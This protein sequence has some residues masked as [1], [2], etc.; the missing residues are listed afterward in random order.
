MKF[1]LLRFGAL[2]VVLLSACSP[3]QKLKKA[4]AQTLAGLRAHVQYLADDKLEGRRT[5]TKGE[6]AAADYITSQFKSIGLKPKGDILVGG[7]Q[8]YDQPFEVN[9]GKQIDSTTHLYINGTELVVGTDYFPFAFSANGAGE[10][11]PSIA[12]REQGVPWFIDLKDAL[13]ENKTNP[14][15][16]LLDFIHTYAGKLSQR[17]A[18]TALV[19][20]NSTNDADGLK[21]SAKDK[22]SAVKL[23]VIYITQAAAK[24]YLSDPSATIQFKFSVSLSDK[25][26]TGHNVVGYIDN[27][28]ATTVVLG[29]HYDHLGYGEDGNSRYEKK[30]PAIH[31]GADDNASGTSTMIELARK[32]KKT[33]NTANNY[34]FIAFSGEE[35]GLYGSK[36]FTESPTIDLSKVSYMINMDM[37]GRLNDSTKTVTIGG[38][39]TSP[40]WAT[41]ITPNQKGA[42]YFTTRIDSSGSGPSDHTSFYKKDI[43]VLFYFTGLHTDYHKPSDD[44]DKINYEGM[45]YILKDIVRVINAMNGK[46]KLAF[47]K[48]RETQTTTSARFSVSLGVMPDYT[49][50]GNGLRVD[51]VIDGR[52]A[53]KAGLKAG[54]IVLQIGDFKISSM[55][56]YMQALSK[57]KKGDKTKVVY[58][59]GADSFTVDVQF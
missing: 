22:S 14:H 45:S 11:T 19:L 43:P 25:V 1:S 17:G 15:F 35:L 44:A 56:A 47:L 6:L 13:E 18:A 12:V 54:D 40:E 58:Q 7:V 20:F 55:D 46:G 31:N 3:S 52:V 2:V 27:G 32:L 57:F 28:A 5:G 4:D 51:G 21:F 10:S 49:Y 29:A 36:H 53:Q 37:V 30:E 9:E 34:L 39:G 48:T 50:S 8:D 23:P 41:I 33:K 38:F 59:R 24:K 26:R 42:G 16:D